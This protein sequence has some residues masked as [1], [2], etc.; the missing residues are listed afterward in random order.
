M[1][2]WGEIKSLLYYWLLSGKDIN[3]SAGQDFNRA[4]G[5]GP[6]VS[7]CIISEKRMIDF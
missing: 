1:I 3:L 4:S 6:L 5:Q 2:A 7:G